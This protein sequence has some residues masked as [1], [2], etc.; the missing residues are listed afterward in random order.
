MSTSRRKL[1]T[2]RNLQPTKAEKPLMRPLSSS[3]ENG[4]IKDLTAQL[5][6]DDS[7]IF[8][9]KDSEVESLNCALSLLTLAKENMV[10]PSFAVADADDKTLCE[11]EMEA[12]NNE[13]MA[14]MEQYDAKK[15]SDA[16]LELV[17]TQLAAQSI[18][19]LAADGRKTNKK[20]AKKDPEA[21][22]HPISAYLF[23]ETGER[24]AITK[25]NSNSSSAEVS[26]LLRQDWQKPK[27]EKDGSKKYDWLAAKDKERSETEVQEYGTIVTKRNANLEG[28]KRCHLKQEKEEALKP[29]KGT[30]ESES[31][32]FSTEENSKIKKVKKKKDPNAPKKDRS[33]YLFFCNENRTKIKAEMTEST[34][35]ELYGE[36]GR[37]WRALS[38][39]KK[40]KYKKMAE[41]DK[42]RYEKEVAEY[43][44]N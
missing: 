15:K 2:R 8:A 40:A 1:P 6:K 4:E 39:S 29:F 34:Q 14:A 30:K 12:Q 27:G 31:A 20:A 19:E 32:A 18:L 44:K 28:E 25:K 22:M 7:V 41:E 16:A 33:A 43:V 35:K 24:E 37:Q 5:A 17:E 10:T 36:I 42:S 21:P 11:T 26:K 13:E 3:D 23:F 38:D 9:S